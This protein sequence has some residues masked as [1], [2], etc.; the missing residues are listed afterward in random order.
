MP[1]LRDAT[2]GGLWVALPDGSVYT[3]DGA[4]Y[5]GGTNNEKANPGGYPCVG[6]VPF[7]DRSGDGYELV[8]DWGDP[9]HS[10][11]S[12]DGGD[13]FRRYRFPRD[14]SAIAA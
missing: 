6:I 4:P 2:S 11:H 8:L 1:M 9:N 3:Y 14:G 10:G 5:L 7:A 13:R 12:A